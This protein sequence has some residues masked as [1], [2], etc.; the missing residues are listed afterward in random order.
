[1]R[2]RVALG[3]GRGDGDVVGD[4]DAVVAEAFD[5]ACPPA[6]RLGGHAR[7]EVEQVN[8]DLHPLLLT[9][10]QPGC[11][12]TAGCEPGGTARPGSAFD[13]DADGFAGAGELEA[14]ELARATA[15]SIAGVAVVDADDHFAGVTTC[16]V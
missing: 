5:H 16:D 1:E 13:D 4:E 10:R 3:N 2:L 9:G 8:S 15:I 11:G 12:T 14:V 6:H 7:A